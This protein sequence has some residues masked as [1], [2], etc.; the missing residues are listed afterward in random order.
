VNPPEITL[1]GEHGVN[2]TLIETVT[3]DV[4]EVFVAVTV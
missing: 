3:A 2:V 4:P 1:V